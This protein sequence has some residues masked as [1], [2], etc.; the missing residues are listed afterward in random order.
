MK[1]TKE[2]DKASDPKP[3]ETADV[4]ALVTGNNQLQDAQRRAGTMT[5]SELVYQRSDSTSSGNGMQHGASC[6]PACPQP[7]EQQQNTHRSQSGND[8]VSHGDSQVCLFLFTTF[9]AF[10]MLC[11]NNLFKPS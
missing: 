11:W 4:D 8:L 3:P 9:L 1:L 2:W 6:P 5:N 10:E 7:F